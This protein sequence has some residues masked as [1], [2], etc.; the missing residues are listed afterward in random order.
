MREKS[1]VG[2]GTAGDIRTR[3]QLQKQLSLLEW[4]QSSSSTTIPLHPTKKSPRWWSIHKT[5]STKWVARV[6]SSGRGRDWNLRS[7]RLENSFEES[8]RSANGFLLYTNI[9]TFCR[10]LE[11]LYLAKI[12]KTTIYCPSNRERISF[13]DPTFSYHSSS[14]YAPNGSNKILC[15]TDSIA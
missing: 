7:N 10:M 12:N 1:L 5:S 15:G 11:C 3:K 13:H 8:R 6:K 9:L 14:G 2:Y 4:K